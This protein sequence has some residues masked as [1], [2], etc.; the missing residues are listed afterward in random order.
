[1]AY[2]HSRLRKTLAIVRIGTGLVFVM[3]GAFKVSSL[4]FGREMLPA[5]LDKALRGGAVSWVYPLL[6]GIRSYGPGRV[7]VAIGFL[8]LFIG[9]A[10]ILGLAVRLA[11]LVGMIY[12]AV[13]ALATWNQVDTAPSMLQNGDH[14]FRNLFPLA[15]MLLLGVGHAGETWG[16]GAVYHRR[17][18]LKWSHENAEQLRD[19]VPFVE[20]LEREPASFEEFAEMEARRAGTKA[21]EQIE[22]LEEH[23][24]PLP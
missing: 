14:Q 24:Q 18:A 8:E 23:S 7:G 20:D 5:I 1:M 17:R 9:I 12:T 6:E 13:L 15:I 16:L 4:E 22:S 3:T 21:V 10:L 19:R 11:A 2:S